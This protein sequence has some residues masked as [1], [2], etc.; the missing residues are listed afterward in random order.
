MEQVLRPTPSCYELKELIG[1][2]ASGC[3]YR[4]IRR[5]SADTIHHEVAIKILNSRNLVG[6]WNEEFKSL[7]T[8]QSSR[9]VRVFGF[10]WMGER[11]ALVLEFIQGVNLSE[12]MQSEQ[13]NN[14]EIRWLGQEIHA[15]LTDLVAHG[16]CHGDLSPNN[17]MVTVEGDIRLLDFGFGN[18][19]MQQK[20]LTPEYAAPELLVGEKATLQT[21]LWSLGQI[22]RKLASP[23]KCLPEGIENLLAASPSARNWTTAN[24]RRPH[25]LG[26][27]VQRVLAA[28]LVR[29]AGTCEMTGAWGK[30]ISLI[31]QWGQVG[32]RA[33]GCFLTVLLCSM[34]GGSSVGRTAP[35]NQEITGYGS[36]SIRSNFGVQIELD[37][38]NLG[39]A[40]M[41]LATMKP[42]TY[43]LRW[44]IAGQRKERTLTLRAG[45][46]IFISDQVLTSP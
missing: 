17:V 36:L 32:T 24:L 34:G 13:L 9:C 20:R 6:V 35:L 42:G 29:T 33:V 40:P 30:K 21:D 10:E 5:D 19:N 28:R 23:L 27:R 2:G 38:R 45:D 22:L 37:G 25:G 3:V 11:P 41:D 1:Q 14:R 43:Q 31:S 26:I 46:H 8:V 18:F 12:L 15:G 44:I 16:L 7:L 39:F 4:A